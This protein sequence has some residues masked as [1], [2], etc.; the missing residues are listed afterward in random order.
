MSG[1]EEI[2][3]KLKVKRRYFEGVRRGFADGAIRDNFL[4]AFSACESFFI[5]NS[6]STEADTK[7]IIAEL[8]EAGKKVYLPRVDGD[9]MVAVPYGETRVGA[10][11]IEEPVGKPYKGKIDVTVIPLLAVNEKGFR[12]GYGKGF[13]DRY[14]KKDKRTKK[15]GLGYSFQIESFEE[16]GWDIPLDLFVC[17]KGIYYYE[18][19]R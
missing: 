16:D 18:N 13:Y 2:R 7:G 17:E 1:K 3:Y 10:F 19:Q 15:V 5:Y 11:G 14:L 12:I 4:N 9:K 6:F 8:L